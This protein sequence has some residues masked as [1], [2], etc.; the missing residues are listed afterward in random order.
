MKTQ[1]GS[2]Q[3]DRVTADH[4]ST[5]QGSKELKNKRFT[6]ITQG[7]VYFKGEFVNT[8]P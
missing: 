4:S 8:L 2:S 3:D 1:H 5:P 6:S 7:R